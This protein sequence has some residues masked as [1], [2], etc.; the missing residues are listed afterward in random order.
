MMR[1]RP[2]R[3]AYGRFLVTAVFLLAL[4]G[5]NRNKQD[6]VIP[7]ENGAVHPAS[8]K[9][10][11]NGEVLPK[12]EETTAQA[13]IRFTHQNSKTPNKYL[14][15]TMGA[16]CAF[17]DYDGDG[18]QDILLLNGAPIPGGKVTGRPTMALYHNN[19]NGTFTDV[20]HQSGL[21]L[22]TMYAMGVAVG[23][24]DNDGLPDFYVSCV[25]GPG[26]L[27]HN[28]GGSRF[29]DVTKTAGVQNAGMFGSSCTWVD[30]DRDGKLDLFICNYVKYPELK[31]DLPC[32]AGDRS[33]RIYCFPLAYDTSRCT[34]YHNDGGSKFTDVS[35][36]SGIAMAQGKALGVS[37]WDYDGDGWPDIFVANDTVPGFLFHNERNGTFKEVGVEAGVAYSESGTAHSGMGIDAADPHNDGKTALLITNYYG[38]QTSY[39]TQIQTDL[40]REDRQPAQIGAA[41][42]DVLGFGIL[43]FDYDNDGLLD[44]VQVNGHIQDDIQIR[45]PKTFFAEKTLIFQNRGD[46]T[47]TECGAK[48]GNPFSNK[49]VGRGL[50]WADINNDGKLNLLVTENNG[51]A[52]L[53]KN[54]T[55]TKNHWVAFHLIGSKSNRDGI[56]SMVTVKAGGIA[57][58]TMVRGGSSYLSQSDLRPHFGLGKEDQ[59]DLEIKWPS[60]TVTQIKGIAANHIWSIHEGSD[61]VEQK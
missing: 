11:K 37:I 23:D 26:H 55:I 10:T 17:I 8:V 16:G 50:A 51:P 57:H 32:F 5:C 7:H 15:E 41:T 24:Y 29:K 31:D 36:K 40:F 9:L 44:I 25:L 13:G 59:I 21:D 34:L 19:R 42:G 54:Q 58:R 53:W 47:F 22:E 60:G 35:V 3:A 56:G 20:T 18:W 12:F 27:F 48:S 46:G 33:S 45:E 30:Y 49:L 38:Q 2:H 1:I 4:A 14:L 61:K 28:E 39:Y 43:Y 6:S 52:H